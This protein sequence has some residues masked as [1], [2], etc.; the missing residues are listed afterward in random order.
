MVSNEHSLFICIHIFMYHI[1]SFVYTC[2]H[3][4]FSPAVHKITCLFFTRYIIYLQVHVCMYTITLNTLSDVP[5][6]V[7]TNILHVRV[8]MQGTRWVIQERNRYLG[9]LAGPIYDLLNSE[10]AQCPNIGQHL[11]VTKTGVLTT[12]LTLTTVLTVILA[13]F[14]RD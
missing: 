13:Y 8:S 5:G 1:H 11:L 6:T 14:N 3:L 9:G 4:A 7:G 10:T 12:N 2:R